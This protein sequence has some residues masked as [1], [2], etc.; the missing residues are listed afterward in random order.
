MAFFA[1]CQFEELEGGREEE[2]RRALVF[3]SSIYACVERC[4][5]DGEAL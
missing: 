2:G 1:F 5:C 3:F 4:E